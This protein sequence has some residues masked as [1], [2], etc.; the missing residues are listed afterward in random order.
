MVIKNAFITEED[1]IAPMGKNFLLQTEDQDQ[2]DQYDLQLYNDLAPP[3]DNYSFS[4]DDGEGLTDLF[5]CSAL[6]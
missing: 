3:V 5:D 1:D 6:N 4:L 2:D